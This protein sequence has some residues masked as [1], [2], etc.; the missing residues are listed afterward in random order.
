MK[1]IQD[2][3]SAVTYWKKKYDVTDRQLFI[4]R[5]INY[6]EYPIIALKDIAKICN[7]SW[8]ISKKETEK[9]IK[10]RLIKKELRGNNHFFHITRY[11]KSKL[12]KWKIEEDQ[13][14]KAQTIQI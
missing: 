2:A 6:F 9:L 7:I 5:K 10:V 1:M 3:R 8:W 11:G 14:L 4:L 12:E 13:V